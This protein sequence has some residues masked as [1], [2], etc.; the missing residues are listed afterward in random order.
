[1]KVSAA[2]EHGTTTLW[3]GRI[4]DFPGTIARASE[5]E[6]LLKELEEELTYHLHWLQQHNE[7]PPSFEKG[8]ITVRE[9]VYNIPNLGESGGEVALFESDKRVVSHNM[10]NTLFRLMDYN[11]ADL[12]TLVESIPQGQLI[13]VPPEKGRSI[14]DILHHV[15]NAEEFY[16]SR[17]G[18]EADQKY[19]EYAGM[20]EQEIDALPI[21][22][23]LHTVR[24]A[25]M[26]TLKELIPEK[27]DRI[28][29]RSEYTDYPHEKWTAY[30]IMRRFLEHE[31]EHYY[32]ILEYLHQPK[33]IDLC[34]RRCNNER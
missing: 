1:M 3:Y 23:R 34:A 32:N 33:R 27:K 31:R 20:S 6:I 9:E 18:E 30:K 11:R 28:F 16:K 17:L 12:L 13:N 22:D 29:T 4:V 7:L 14:V 25:C 10:L 8:H 5:R 26:R 24:K 19:A 15:C 2:L 21:L